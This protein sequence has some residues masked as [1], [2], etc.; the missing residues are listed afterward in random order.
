MAERGQCCRFFS[1][2]TVGVGPS[3]IQYSTD[4]VTNTPPLFLSRDGFLSQ[5]YDGASHLAF[6]VSDTGSDGWTAAFLCRGCSEW[7]G[8]SLDPN[9]DNELAF[10]TSS[11]PVGAEDHD[12]DVVYH[13][14]GRGLAVDFWSAKLGDEEWDALIVSLW[15]GEDEGP[16][17]LLYWEEPAGREG[18]DGE[19]E[20]GESARGQ[21]L[22]R[23]MDD[24]PIRVTILP[25]DGGESQV[26]E[27][28]GE[29]GETGTGEGEEPVETEIEEEGPS[30]TEE[31]ADTP[32]QSTTE[33]SSDVGPSESPAETT[34]DVPSPSE[35]EP[36][37]TADETDDAPQQPTAESSQE[38]P[39]DAP[40]ESTDVP[41]VTE[42]STTPETPSP[43]ESTVV[44]GQ[45]TAD[46]PAVT[47]SPT[48]EAPSGSD[49]PVETTVDVP[50]ITGSP[51]ST[52]VPDDPVSTST[53][54]CLLPLGLICLL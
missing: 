4:R 5:P 10:T 50:V 29:L 8:G 37:E 30:P 34:V 48:T 35:P 23:R 39:T 52:L 54:T 44:P 24:G 6:P 19:D 28:P 49:P 27:T 47:G 15:G 25:S 7:E 26:T 53:R 40:E 21:E 38:S 2:G 1:M 9:G 20:V 32:Q 11:Q 46:V 51:G 3:G 22:K 42:D 31:P 18:F 16:D 36:I 12:M 33:A 17:P 13:S 14:E 45:T 41:V 43:T